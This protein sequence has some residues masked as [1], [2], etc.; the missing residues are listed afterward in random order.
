MKDAETH[1]SCYKIR[2]WVKKRASVSVSVDRNVY[3]LS[4]VVDNQAQQRFTHWFGVERCV[5]VCVCVCSY[6]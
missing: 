4:Q 3:S 6:E 2:G 1:V 5:R